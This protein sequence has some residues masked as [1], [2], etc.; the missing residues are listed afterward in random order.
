M[1]FHKCPYEPTL[2]IHSRSNE[3]NFIVYL[4]VDDFIYTGNDHPMFEDFKQSM[5]KE[6]EMSDLGMMHYFLGLEV[7]QSNKGTF[8][9]QT[10]YVHE[11]FKKF[12]MQDCNSVRTPNNV[13]VK[14]TKDSQGKKN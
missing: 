8:I 10:K 9:S 3:K 13:G 6:F 5:M 11:I 14:L 2:F 7:S 4:Y 12:Q 1:D